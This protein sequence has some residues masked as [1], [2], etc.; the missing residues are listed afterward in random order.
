MVGRRGRLKT[1]FLDFYR[2]E[3]TVNST[4][5]T[6]EVLDTAGTDQFATMRDLYI[7]NGQG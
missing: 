2:K 1:V 6:L 7:R 4:P 3:I 5:A